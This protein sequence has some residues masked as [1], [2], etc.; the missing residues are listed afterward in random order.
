ME[1][2]RFA[3]MTSSQK[4]LLLGSGTTNNNTV[5][6]VPDEPWTL[7][8]AG[9]AKRKRAQ[10]LHSTVVEYKTEK[11]IADIE[12]M[13]IIQWSVQEQLLCFQIVILKLYGQNQGKNQ[14][15]DFTLLHSWAHASAQISKL[16]SKLFSLQLSCHPTI[17][18]L[19]APA[20]FLKNQ[21]WAFQ[22]VSISLQYLNAWGGGNKMGAMVFHEKFQI[23]TVLV[24]SRC[25]F[26]ST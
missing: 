3:V 24:Q 26:F 17:P 2:S 18:M 20:Q 21:P 6:P 22:L 19:S 25:R 4:I 10:S 15:K 16:R 1:A 9:E 13:A 5:L 8:R 23:S 12:L 14:R 11:K 7:R